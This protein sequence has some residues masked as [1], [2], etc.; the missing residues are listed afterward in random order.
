MTGRWGGEEFVCIIKHVGEKQLT[1]VAEKL[2]SLVES[3]KIRVEGEPLNVTVSVG[4]TLGGEASW[5][6]ERD[7]L[8]V[9]PQLAEAPS[10]EE[11]WG[12]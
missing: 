2:R 10:A 6:A 4:G 7:R 12:Q 11:D 3:L 5:Q 8:T 9:A 1:T